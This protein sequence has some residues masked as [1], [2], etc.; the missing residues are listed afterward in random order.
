MRCFRFRRP[1][2]ADDA[3]RAEEQLLAVSELSRPSPSPSRR[4]GVFF[5]F[6][7][8]FRRVPPEDLYEAAD[9]ALLPLM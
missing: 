4:C 6:F 5:L 9:A 7:F 3:D 8:F 2:A 1:E